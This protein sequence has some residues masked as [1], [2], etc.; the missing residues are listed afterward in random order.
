MEINLTK[1][2]VKIGD[3]QMT[4]YSRMNVETDAIVP[5]TK[6]DIAK[7]IA[8]NG[9]VCISEKQVSQDK[10][11]IIGTAK[12]NML[13]L[14]DGDV[15]G[16]VKCLPISHDFNHVIDAKG[17]TPDMQVVA[18]C[19]TEGF[20]CSVINS[21]KVNVRGNVTLGVKVVR[22]DVIDIAVGAED[23]AP[24]EVKTEKLRL[25]SGCRPAEGK[26]IVRQQLDAP[27]SKPIIGEIL[28]VSAHPCIQEIQI[29]D[30]KA[31]VK[32]QV[33]ISTLY[34]AED[35][36]CSMQCMEHTATFSEVLDVDGAIEDMEGEAYCCISDIYSEIR[37]DS[38]GEA[39][40]IGVEIV[41]SVCVKAYEIAELNAVCDAY[42]L[43]GEADIKRREHNLERFV[44]IAT[45]QHTE[46]IRIEKPE[47]LPAIHQVCDMNASATIDG[48]T[49]E[50]G[51]AVAKGR[52]KTTIIYISEDENMPVCSLNNTSEFSHSFDTCRP[53][54]DAA[55][56]VR[57]NVDHASYNLS[58][59]EIEA[60]VVI[61][62]TLK[63]VKVGKCELVESI[64]VE[65]EA[66]ADNESGFVV[67]FV[68][69]GD[70]LWNIAKRYK[71]TV[72][73]IKRTNNIEGDRI[74]VG[75]KIFLATA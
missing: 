30:G 59:G 41:L 19:E 10:I 18:E 66:P 46:K 16:K 70:T 57:I 53:G 31:V 69:S 23:D 6:P 25:L 36:T 8:V 49:I 7:V 3:V 22:P 54:S 29:L 60:R 62:L 37:D 56:D 45:A 55:F 20:S 40:C 68:Q 51:V 15:I 27:T 58:S 75:Q 1:Q 64:T 14:P 2:P 50:D 5:D 12:I 21:R 52:I 38:D 47:M 4:K 32:G 24:I 48:I 42:S 74:D 67:Y 44:D 11:Y 65:D 33:K 35:E 26:I 71:T 13:Y 61:G 72:D 17:I 63:A 9:N 28:K 43:R 73:E 39:R 34:S